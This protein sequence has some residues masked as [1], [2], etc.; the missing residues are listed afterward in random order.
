MFDN[1][2][3]PKKTPKSGSGKNDPQSASVPSPA[4]LQQYAH[5]GLDLPALVIKEWGYR[6]RRAFWYAMLALFIGGLLALSLVGGF[7]YLVMHNHPTAAGS[8]LGA[9]AIGMVAGF[10]AARL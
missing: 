3:K 1:A 2:G 4:L 8:L 5:V 9:G 6:H 7:I 10:R